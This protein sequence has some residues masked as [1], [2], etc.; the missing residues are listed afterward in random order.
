MATVRGMHGLCKL[1]LHAKSRGD[2]GR[3][4]TFGPEKEYYEKRMP[5]LGIERN[6]SR[7][8]LFAWQRPEGPTNAGA[9]A[10]VVVAPRAFLYP[11]EHTP[12]EPIAW[13]DLPDEGMAACVGFLFTRA[14]SMELR[15][16]KQLL[17]A[18]RLPNGEA[19]LVCVK[20]EPFDPDAFR[21]A[22]EPRLN[23]SEGKFLTAHRFESGMENLRGLLVATPDTS[24]GHA[25]LV[26]VG[27]LRIAPRNN[28]RPEP[29]S[30]M[31]G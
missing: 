29:R 8:A 19:V 14:T 3:W 18:H 28:S 5:A 30:S 7:R 2:G 21:A 10:L 23:T 24:E 1:S 13:V 25:T 22:N 6:E 31:M 11:Q 17:A 27:G 20:H 9:L 4:C 16:L 12:A 26:D 15:G